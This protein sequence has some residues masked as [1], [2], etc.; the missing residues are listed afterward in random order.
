MIKKFDLILY[1][2][3]FIMMAAVLG[4]AVRL[5]TA[6]AENVEIYVN[7]KLLYTYKLSSEQRI[8]KVPTDIGGVEIEFKDEKVRVT[9]SFS[10]RKLCVKQGWISGTGETIIGVPDKLLVKITGSITSNVDV[11]LR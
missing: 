11:I 4:A 10:P 5:K 9:K 7:N 6:E 2:V 8:L 3:I 1:F